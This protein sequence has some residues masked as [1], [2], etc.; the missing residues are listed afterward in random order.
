M[1]ISET[2]IMMTY[3]S[4]LQMTHILWKRNFESN[5]D[6]VRREILVQYRE[7]RNEKCAVL[8]I[9]VIL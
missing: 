1:V 9:Q 2:Y 8:K 5:F 7:M 4:L 6:L 3:M